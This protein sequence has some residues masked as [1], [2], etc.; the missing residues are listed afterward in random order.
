MDWISLEKGVT[1]GKKLTSRPLQLIML[2]DIKTM[3]KD[4][5]IDEK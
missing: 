3:I 5:N 1:F 2:V 4:D